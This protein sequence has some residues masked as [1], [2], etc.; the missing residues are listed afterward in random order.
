M[1]IRDRLYGGG[2]P[3]QGVGIAVHTSGI[4]ITGFFSAPSAT[5]GSTTIQASGGEGK[6]DAFLA[7]LNGNGAVSYTHLDVYK[8]Q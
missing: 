3:D 7:K 6:Y 2:S 8:R 1:C 5:F 4:Y